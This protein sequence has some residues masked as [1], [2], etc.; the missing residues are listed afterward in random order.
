L[1]R[2]SVEE[3]RGRRMRNLLL[4]MAALMGVL[5]M[6]ASAVRGF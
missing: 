2:N 6:A 5:M 4:A 3:R 1:L